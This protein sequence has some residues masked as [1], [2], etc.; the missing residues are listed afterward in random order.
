MR[1][2]N[3]TLKTPSPSYVTQPLKLFTWSIKF[4][5][6]ANISQLRCIPD[7][8]PCYA[9][10][11]ANPANDPKN[12]TRV[13]TPI[14]PSTKITS[15]AAFKPTPRSRAWFGG[16]LSPPLGG[17]GLARE[18]NTPSTGHRA[19]LPP[20]SSGIES[21]PGSSLR[22]VGNVTDPTQTFSIGRPHTHPEPTWPKF[23]TPNCISKGM[24][25]LRWGSMRQ[26]WHQRGEVPNDAKTGLPGKP[27][28]TPYYK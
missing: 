1:S 11:E 9:P 15:S 3:W 2:L 25:K 22:W 17:G 21:F 24:V 13:P 14:H 27:T 7:P 10:L 26:W 18:A 28:V 6:K 12:R 23:P 8:V 20:G 4:I 19:G 16:P 5:Q